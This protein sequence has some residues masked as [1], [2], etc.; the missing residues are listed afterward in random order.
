MIALV[1]DSTS[2]LPKEIL[3]KYQIEVVPLTVHF[4]EKVYQDKIDLTTEEFFAKMESSEKMPT[5]SQP[6][7]GLFMEK[8]RELSKEYDQILSIHLSS[9][10][11]GTIESARLAAVEIDDC[12]IEIIDS[13]V[14]TLGLGF[15]VMMAARLRD[16]GKDIAFIKEKIENM[17]KNIYIAFTVSDLSYLEKGGRI[18][19]AQ[20]FLGSIFNFNPI[21]ELDGS[22]GEILP[23]EKVRGAKKTNRRMLAIMQEYFADADQAWVGFIKGIDN[24][25]QITYKED[26]F[27]ELEQL[28]TKMD[29]NFYENNISAVIGCHTGPFIYGT[30][31]IKGDLMD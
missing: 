11:S 16:Q 18:G 8:Y 5:T 14:T 29:I 2:D 27:A 6:S 3:E 17:R 13:R 24:K 19:K 21:L 22:Q 20:A 4:G 12:Q 31:M 10:L 30:I 9:K 7:V 25:S 28:K 15:L 26:L 1:T 23:R